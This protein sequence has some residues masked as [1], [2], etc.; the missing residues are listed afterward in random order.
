[1]T[2]RLPIRLPIRLLKRLAGDRS[3]A[4]LMECA[5]GLAMLTPL[6]LGTVELGR[7]M[8]VQQKLE[9]LSATVGDLNARGDV[10]T[11]AQVTALFDATPHVMQPFAFGPIGRVI[12]SQVTT[13]G[14]VYPRIIWQ[15]LGGGTLSTTS[16]IGTASHNATLPHGLTMAANETVIV[17]EVVYDFTP[18]L[19]GGF[20][21]PQ[22][23]HLTSAYRPRM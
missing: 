16:S 20:L 4:A 13:V 22:R 10:L 9:R 5:L 12:V 17:T 3:G 18:L 15:Q 19:L 7:F 21:E 6:I 8:L 14:Y 23:I 1:M 11:P 2:P